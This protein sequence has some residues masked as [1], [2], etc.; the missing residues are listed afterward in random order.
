MKYL[1]LAVGLGLSAAVVLVVPGSGATA[2]MQTAT[3]V[4]RA[5][6]VAN[7][8]L[9]QRPVWTQCGDKELRTYCAK[10]TAPRD[11][12]N[13]YSGNDIQIAVSKV[14]PA[15]GKPSRVIFGTLA[16]R[17]APAS[18]WR[19][20]WRARRRWRRITSQSGSTRGAPVTA[21]T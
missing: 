13:Q 15:K 2:S 19:R 3:V 4:D 5:H 1:T 14:A 16:A 6:P 9:K 11:W 20:T 8:Y 17:V 18:G 7:K 10:I 12:A 21:P